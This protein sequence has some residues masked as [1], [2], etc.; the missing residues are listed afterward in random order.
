MARKSQFPTMNQAAGYACVRH[1][2]TSVRAAGTA[3]GFSLAETM[4]ATPVND[5]YNNGVRIRSDGRVLSTMVSAH[6]P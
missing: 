2:L 4:R 1:Y 5:M 6:L 3:E